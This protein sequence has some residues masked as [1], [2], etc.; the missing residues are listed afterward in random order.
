LTGQQAHDLGFVDE[1][2]NQ[3]TAMDRVQQLSGITRANLIRYQ[4]PLDLGGLFRL[5][6]RSEPAA[7][8]LDLGIDVPQ[9]EAGR[10]YFLAPNPFH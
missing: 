2:G 8:K 10:L 1:L 7:L 5:L 6:G 3:D 9:L 4:R